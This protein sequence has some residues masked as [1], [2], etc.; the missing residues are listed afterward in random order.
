M[1]NHKLR[2]QAAAALKAAGI[3]GKLYTSPK[4]RAFKHM[5]ADVLR[6]LIRKVSFHPGDLVNDCDGFNHR[7][8]GY[9]PYRN[10]AGIMTVD[11]LEFENNHLSCGCPAGPDTAWTVDEIIKFHTLTAEDIAYNKKLGWWSTKSQTLQDRINAGEPITDEYGI[12]N[13]DK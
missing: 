9:R 8:V 7:V 11:Q 6:T 4:R 13:Y 12:R 2:I 5:P 1:G 10:W 3:K